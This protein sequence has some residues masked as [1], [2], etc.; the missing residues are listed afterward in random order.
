[1]IADR[2]TTEQT[3]RLMEVFP[4]LQELARPLPARLALKVKGRIVF[5]DPAD[6]VAVQAEGN[7]VLLWRAS[8]SYMLRE[9]IS[10]VAK[11]LEPYGFIRIH[12]SVLVNSS[13][14]EE[15]QPHSTGEYGLKMK[16]GKEYTV[17]RTYK[18]NLKSLA[19]Y[20]IGAGA[21]FAD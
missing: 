18:K 3:A 5:I 12:R 21:F 13:F 1:M 11:K 7:Y 15:I 16:G 6:C 8:D 4:M 17:T 20:W 19:A 2:I 9:S 10:A 14:V